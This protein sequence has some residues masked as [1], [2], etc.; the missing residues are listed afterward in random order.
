MD[1]KKKDK[2]PGWEVGEGQLVID[3][4]KDNEDFVFGSFDGVK[5]KGQGGKGGK[6]LKEEKWGELMTALQ[7][8]YVDLYFSV[9]NYNSSVCCNHNSQ[10]SQG[11]SNE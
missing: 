4:V 8:R 6:A 9:S 3:F 11:L 2:D 1:V 10:L 5:T 7:A